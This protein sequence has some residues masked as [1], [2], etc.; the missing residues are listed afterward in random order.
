MKKTS[1]ISGM[2]GWRSTMTAKKRK[3]RA[4]LPGFPSGCSVARSPIFTPN[5][6]AA[7][8]ISSM[9]KLSLSFRVLTR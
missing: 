4:L 7:R 2:I 9:T 5:G 6:Y 8:R 3:A 1:M